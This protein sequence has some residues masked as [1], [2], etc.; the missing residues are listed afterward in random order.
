MT[1]DD[2]DKMRTKLAE[3][4]SLTI[5]EMRQQ[6]SHRNNPADF[7]ARAKNRLH[8]LRIADFDDI[9]S[10]RI[11]GTKRFYAIRVGNV[12][13]ILWWDPKHQICPSPKKH[14]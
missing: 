6:G 9:F 8:E 14:T 5:V 4:E 1:K 10:F 12:F 3:F 13:E 11:T 7:T 2:W